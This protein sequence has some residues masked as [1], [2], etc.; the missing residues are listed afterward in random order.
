MAELRKTLAKFKVLS[1]RLKR[2]SENK[3]IN[4]KLGVEGSPEIMAQLHV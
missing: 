2:L 1:A 4:I 3:R